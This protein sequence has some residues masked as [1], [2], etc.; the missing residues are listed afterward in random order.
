MRGTCRNVLKAVSVAALVVAVVAGCGGGDRPQRSVA[1]GVPR[2]LAQAWEARAAA[3]A[4]AARAGNSCRAQRLAASLRDDVVSSEHKL[5]PRLRTPLL[6][7]VNALADRITCTRVVT[8][9]TPS[10][11]PP[12]KPKP[13]PKPPKPHGPP[14]H[15]K[16]HDR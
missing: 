1:H 16:G 13:N 4:S 6:T 15:D 12:P 2:T 8:V 14:G 5:P 9:P 10:K 11:K 3:I 7:G